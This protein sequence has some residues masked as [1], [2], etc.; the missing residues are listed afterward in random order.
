MKFRVLASLLVWLFGQSFAVACPDI[1][2]L[3]DIQ[4]DGKLLVV[5]FG[6]S[7]TAGAQDPKH[8]GYPGRLAKLMKQIEVV[9][10]GLYGE[11]STEGRNRAISEISEFKKEADYVIILE[12][13]NDYYDDSPSLEDAKANLLSM[14]ATAKK[15]GAQVLL[16]SLTATTRGFQRAWVDGLN[17]E[18]KKLVDIDFYSLGTSIVGFDGLHPSTE[19]YEEM[20]KL[21]R[22]RL[23]SIAASIRPRDADKDGLY[24]FEEDKRHTNRRNSDSDGDGIIDG[25]EVWKYKTSPRKKD[26]DRDRLSDRDEIKHYHTDPLKKDTDGDGISDGD[27]VQN[28]TDPRH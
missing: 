4:C 12:G 2:G 22:R 10:L 11:N 14:I 21:V 9:N 5:T 3:V 24:D 20:A 27:E 23:K 26:T 8:L 19:G 6:D 1:N 18:I 28:F 16:G 15:T 7:I 17:D 13:T 25:K